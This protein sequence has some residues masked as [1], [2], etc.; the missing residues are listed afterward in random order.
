M[1][2]VGLYGS[3]INY[4]S[5]VKLSVHWLSDCRPLEWQQGDE[6]IVFRY[7]R[8][9]VLQDT[10]QGIALNETQLEWTSG[11]ALGNN[12]VSLSK[13]IIG[14]HS[15]TQNACSVRQWEFHKRQW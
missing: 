10:E 13:H 15:S 3:D 5:D 7:Q 1:G 6:E 2:V 11:P 14:I 8:R 9:S 12:Q 4:V